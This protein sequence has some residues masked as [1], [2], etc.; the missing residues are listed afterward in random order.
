M[1]K[2][3]TK[4]RIVSIFVIM[5]M[6]CTMLIVPNASAASSV[7]IGK[8]H[9]SVQIGDTKKIDATGTNLKWKSSD[10]S[11][12]KVSST[13]VIT[14][15][16]MGRATVTASS[17]SS[18][19]SCEITC[20][21]YKGIDVSTWNRDYTG[22][23]GNS[24]NWKKVKAEGV[25]FAIIRAGFGW[26]DYPNQMD[27]QFLN[28]IKGCVENDI[29]F[30]L[31]FYSYAA[32]TYQASLEANYLLRILRDYAPQYMDKITLPIA[33]D[34]EEEFMYTMDSTVFT[35][36]IITFSNI[37]KAAGFDA[38]VYGNSGTFYNMDMSRLQANNIT[39]WYAM[40]PNSPNF[41]SPETI[42]QT[43]IVPKIW[44]YAS[45]GTVN[46]AGYKNGV[47]VN[48]LY[49]MTATKSDFKDTQTQSTVAS[50]GSNSATLKWT[51]ANG[52]RYNLY[53][54]LLNDE[55]KMDATT[56]RWLYSGKKTSFEDT[57]MA[58][59]KGY[60]Y[61]TDT[62]YTGDFLDKDYQKVVSGSKKGTYVYN[63]YNGDCD[64]DS[65]ITLHDAILAQEISISSIKSNSVQRYAA[66]YDKNNVIN[67]ADS[68]IIQKLALK[69]SS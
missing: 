40:W 35:D 20:G 31:Y 9:Y 44:Q 11:V 46:G 39:F 53:R 16:S 64:L 48:A 24:V 18:S 52:A 60:Y 13:G 69:I 45:D 4:T 33:Y 2:K 61:Y 14:G 17:G 41:S 8:A 36:M 65:K 5:L 67:L 49:M 37:I 6:L 55:G 12:V 25:D 19:A 1:N 7:K 47:D 68:L 21:Y 30:G 34:L 57:S 38:M 63:V 22:G 15:V 58:Y 28:N 51:A 62:F 50:Q 43:G 59:G 29:P 3:M 42:G 27:N 26:E 56:R 54:C 23:N 32:N 66:D 10:T